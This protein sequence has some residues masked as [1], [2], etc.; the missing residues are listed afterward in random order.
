[1]YVGIDAVDIHRM[2]SFAY[3]SHWQLRRVFT[4]HEIA[5]CF[6]QSTL[7][8]SRL[9]TRFAAKE[10]TWKALSQYTNPP[11]FLT[12]CRNTEIISHQGP[13]LYIPMYPNL[14]TSVSLTHTNTSATA[15]VIVSPVTHR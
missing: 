4:E 11:A 12:L 6:A 1:M 13:R 14:S 8:L 9:A 5:Y 3:A 2:R 7:T 15:I 10:A